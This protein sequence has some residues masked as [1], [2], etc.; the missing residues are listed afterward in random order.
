MPKRAALLFDQLMVALQKVVD[1][2][3]RG[4][5]GGRT[6]PRSSGPHLPVGNSQNIPATDDQTVKVA[7]QLAL[8]TSLH[9]LSNKFVRKATSFVQK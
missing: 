1:N 8:H 5:L 4:E 2:Q 9:V 6:L 3:N 7:L